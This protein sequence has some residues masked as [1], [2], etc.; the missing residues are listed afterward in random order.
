MDNS[1][2]LNVSAYFMTWDDIQV[3][4]EDPQPNLFTLGIVNF[5]QAEIKGVEVWFSWIPDANWNIEA[6]LGYNDGKLSKADTL[7]EGS[8]A[9]ITVPTGTQLPIVPD[10]KAHVN[11]TYSFPTIWMN[12]EPYVMGRFTHTGESVNSLAG[13]ESSPFLS[14]VVNQDDWQ[15]LDL[16]FGLEGENWAVSLFVDNLTDEKAQLFFNNR[17]AQQRLSVNQPRT[18]GIN[19]RFMRGVN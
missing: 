10:L 7:F 15:T 1:L 11:V 3:Q 12:A 16:Q 8:E 5:P 13:I 19:F 14:P 18:F 17:F 4:A 9:P 2:R 6:T